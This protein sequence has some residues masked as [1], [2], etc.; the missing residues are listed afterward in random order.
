[1]IAWNDADRERDADLFWP[2]LLLLVVPVFAWAHF[3][4]RPLPEVDVAPI[5]VEMADPLP[6][7]SDPEIRLLHVR[8]GVIC[9]PWPDTTGDDR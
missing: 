4:N 6:C 2:T 5:V 3:E 7:E 9:S 8:L 1:M